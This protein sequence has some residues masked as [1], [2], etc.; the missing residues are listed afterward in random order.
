MKN[1]RINLKKWLES[2]K[3]FFE[4]FSFIFL[5]TASII[6]AWFSYQTSSKQLELSSLEHEPIINIKR[7]FN[8][9]YEFL[10]VN[11]VGYHLFD[12]QA[13]YDSYMEIGNYSDSIVSPE[14][15]FQIKIGDYFN[16]NYETDNTVGELSSI[17]SAPYMFNETKRIVGECRQSFGQFYD[18]IGFV[19]LLRLSYK[20][21]SKKK[22]ERFYLVDAFKVIELSK[23]DYEEKKTLFNEQNIDGHK[24]LKTITKDEV[25]ILIHKIFQNS[26]D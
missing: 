13:N 25:F 14:R 16:L 1:K 21:E 22:I 8:E 15:N 9:K 17:S 7:D 6:V 26:K 4:V 10:I 23:S 24:Y 2:N 20:N 11:N 19:H 3:V 18:Y 12:F 5:G